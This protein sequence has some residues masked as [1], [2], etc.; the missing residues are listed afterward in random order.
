LEGRLNG[1]ELLISRCMLRSGEDILLDD[2]TV[3]MLQEKLGVKVTVVEN[4]GADLFDK[5][6]GIG[7]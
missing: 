4:D 6:M 5:I 1:S 2:Y 3:G 7:V